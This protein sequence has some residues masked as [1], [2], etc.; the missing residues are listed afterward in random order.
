MTTWLAVPV[1]TS[2]E[3]CWVP[4]QT[5][6][7]GSDVHYPEESPAHPVTVDGFRIAPRQ[8]TNAEYDAF[9]DATGYQTV[10]E[11]PLDPADFPGAPAENLQPGSMVF[12]R[13]PGPVDLRHINLWWTWTPG[14]SWRH[15][16]GPG[17]DL[18]GLDRHPVVHAAAEDAEAYAAW[19]GLALPTEAEW[20]AAARGGLEHAAYVWGRSPSRLGGAA[21]QLLAR[22]L[23]VARG[24]GLRAYRGGGLVPGEPL[25]SLRHGRERLGVDERLVCLGPRCGAGPGTVLHPP[26]PARPGGRAQLRPEPAAVPGAAPGDQG[27]VV[28]LRGQLLPAIP[29]GGPLAS[30]GRHR[31]EPYRFPLCTKG[32]CPTGQHFDS[33]MVSS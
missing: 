6:T 21:G 23:H 15:P 1:T 7:M 31:D 5:F 2:D 19:A 26:Q 13:T 27:R 20:E 4:A 25:R 24:T 29:P 28:P 14:A 32:T 30:D 11:R 8:V 3:L 17:S 10:A 33:T 16:S 9:V 22:R 12:T 18:D